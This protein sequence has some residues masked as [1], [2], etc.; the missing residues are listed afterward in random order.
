MT[1]PVWTALSL[2]AVFL[3]ATFY[4]DSTCNIPGFTSIRP[5]QSPGRESIRTTSGPRIRPV[6]EAELQRKNP[7]FFSIRF[8]QGAPDRPDEEQVNPGTG[9]P[10]CQFHHTPLR[11]QRTFIPGAALPAVI[12][13]TSR[14][15]TRNFE[16]ISNSLRRN[17]SAHRHK[18]NCAAKFRSAVVV[19][20][21]FFTLSETPVQEQAQ[22]T[23]ETSHKETP[24]GPGLAAE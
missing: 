24:E 20:L 11:H 15:T 4:V 13:S 1:N 23:T 12:S 8:T 14:Q 19:R 18:G 16:Y 10:G 3:D 21:A 6:Q 9:R 17:S 2:R 5:V 7:A 22:S